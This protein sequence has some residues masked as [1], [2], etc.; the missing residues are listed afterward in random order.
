MPSR[1]SAWLIDER[2]AK[3][4]PLAK[5]VTI[6]RGSENT[7]ILRDPAVSRLHCE[8]KSQAG[9]F[10]LH[11]LGASGTKVNGIHVGGE[12]TLREGDVVEI[13]FSKLRFTTRPPTNEMF[14]I[15]RDAPTSV[16][17]LETPTRVT[18]AAAHPLTVASRVRRFLRWLTG[19]VKTD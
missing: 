9:S 15:P 8:V 2:W 12:C 5:D 6:G 7:I 11:A 18:L 14:V 4:Y 16:D 19:H 1:A 3:A 10:V 17:E 13:A